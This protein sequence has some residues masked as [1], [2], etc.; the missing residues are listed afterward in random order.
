VQENVQD[1][2]RRQANTM[3]H[4]FDLRYRLRNLKIKISKEEFS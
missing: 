2:K 3:T 4:Y 1:E